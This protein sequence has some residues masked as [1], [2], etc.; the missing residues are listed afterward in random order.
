[1]QEPTANRQMLEHW[2]LSRGAAMHAGWP[3]GLPKQ[4]SWPQPCSAEHASCRAAVLFSHAATLKFGRLVCLEGRGTPCL[5]MLSKHAGK[6]PCPD[7]PRFTMREGLFAFI[8]FI[9]R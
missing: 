4:T 3:S 2:R 9:S 7:H 8:L 5:Q 1:M 6:D